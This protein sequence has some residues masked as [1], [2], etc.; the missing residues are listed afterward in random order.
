MQKWTISLF[1]IAALLAA[2]CG[3]ASEPDVIATRIPLATPLPAE[4]VQQM[5]TQPDIAHGAQVFAENCT[6]CHGLG[7]LGDG[8]LVASGSITGVPNFADPT[9]MSA[10]TP[11]EL[12][13]IISDGRIETFMP[14]WGDVLPE[15][16]RWAVA[17]Y[18]YGLA[19]GAAP[20]AAQPAPV[21]QP[22]PVALPETIG[23]ISGTVTNG[24]GGMSVPDGLSVALQTLNVDFEET[25]FTM[26]V[27]SSGTYR[28]ENVPIRAD[29]M[30]VVTLVHNGIV[31]SSDYIIGDPLV[32]QHDVP[33]MIYE[34]TTDPVVVEISL[35]VTRIERLEDDIVFTE[36][37]NFH[38]A[39]DRLFQRPLAGYDA[40]GH[41][42]LPTGATILN[43]AELLRCCVVEN[44]VLY[45]LEPLMPGADH[46]IRAVYTLPETAPL[47]PEFAL[48]YRMTNQLELMLT[49]GGFS[50]DAQGFVSRGIQHF[51]TGAYDI[52][53][54]D[55]PPI[56]Q[57]VR[58]SLS[59]PP[60]QI[61]PQQVLPLA[62]G[63]LGV[64]LMAVSA[65]LWWRTRPNR[66]QIQQKIT[67]QIAQ[68]DARYRAGRIE[69]ASYQ[70]RREHL[71]LQLAHHYRQKE[72]I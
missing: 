42:R 3:L 22:E 41:L 63:V 7:G 51:S 34:T 8:A 16:D 54:A 29:S 26:G 39:S 21:A 64:L 10:R 2:G 15:T 24:T 57:T 49:P 62:I 59:D 31:F 40:A 14:P 13:Q 45:D 66:A 72:S 65:L 50:L 69:P 71:K 4:S 55:A 30:Y 48:D 60:I 25:A 35:L 67:S 1:V 56:G 5:I 61:D 58:Y 33:L 44:G 20:I 52:Y 53:L 27:V 19:Q 32:R 23:I 17:M 68:L 11:E 18:V 36:I 6:S 28:F 47:T 43:E 46:M 38:N 12:F 37:V 9:T 70:A